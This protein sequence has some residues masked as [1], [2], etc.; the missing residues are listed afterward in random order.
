MKK[1]IFFFLII[2]SGVCSSLR[3][4]TLAEAKEL[5]L[6]G[7][8]AKALPAF[9]AE[10]ESRPTDASVNQWYGVCLFET[11]GDITLAEKCLTFAS[12]KRIRDSFLY[13]GQIYALQYKFDESEKMFNTYKSLLKKKGDETAVAKLEDKEKYMSRI[14]RMV[15]NT[16]DIQIVDSVVIDK[17]EFLDAYLLSQSGG[18]LNYFNKI[19]NANRNVESVVYMN[20]KGSKIYFGQPDSSAHYRLYSMEMLMD[21]YGNEKPLSAT[22]F[23]LGNGNT[24]YPFIMS[25]GVTIYF[26][27]E[28]TESLG[29]YDL[30][31]SRYNM[32][33]DVYLA[34]ER[35]NMPFNS[36]YNDYMLVIDEEK[37]IGWFASDR[38]QEDGQVCIY[39]FIPNSTTTIIQGE[40]LAYKARRALIL[41]IKDS[42][43]EGKDYKD[44]LALARKVPVVKPKVVRDFE[45]VINDN[46]TYYTLAD[47]KNSTA[48]D[49]YFKV[50]QLKSDLKLLNEEL[51][52]QRDDYKKTNIDGKRKM[53]NSI[54]IKEQEVER[55]QDEIYKLEVD[56]RNQE[57]KELKEERY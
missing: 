1:L 27:S 2:I 24:N 50:I 54:L 34:P 41:A 55:M 39:T 32:N 8:Y 14:R 37:G 3:A 38:F 47:F 17:A 12:K 36:P 42:W 18:S 52:K 20:E 57:I 40:D 43:K 33:N 56:S 49:T 25:D 31:V 21:K 22:N 4:Q 45:F 23:N 9:K 51:Q 6:A 46:H 13:L 26:A 19:F 16:E 44:E 11:G 48:R 28:D 10:Y 15:N 5:Y 30:F 29:G 35:L 53:A 7:E